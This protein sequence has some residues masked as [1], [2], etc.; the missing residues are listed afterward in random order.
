MSGIRTLLTAVAVMAL[1]A[2]GRNAKPDLPPAAGAVTPIVHIAE[3]RIYV[4][5]EAALT[6]PEPVAEGPIAQCF[7]VAAQR[8]AAI[9]RGNA[10]LKAIASKQ[11]TE[12][13]P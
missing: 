1:A 3:R 7:D 2:C 9:E 6:K 12:V 13:S 5:I 4:P 8:R 11:G 10:K